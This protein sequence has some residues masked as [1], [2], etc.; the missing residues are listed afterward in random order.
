MIP[1]G[2]LRMI[3]QGQ[4]LLID[5]DEKTLAEMGFKDMQVSSYVFC[6]S[7]LSFVGERNSHWHWNC[8]VDCLRLGWRQSNEEERRRK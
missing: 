1:D 8:L 3:T 7:F 2:Q 5:Y 4:E 6:E